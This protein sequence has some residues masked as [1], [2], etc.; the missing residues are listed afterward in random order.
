MDADTAIRRVSFAE[1]QRSSAEVMVAI[2]QQRSKL[3]ET[4]P[5]DEAAIVAE[6]N[7]RT[8]E[9]ARHQVDKTA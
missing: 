4:S 3:A 6:L 5:G 9:A 8:A 2:A 7:D 1:A